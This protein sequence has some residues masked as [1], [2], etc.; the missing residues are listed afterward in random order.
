MSDTDSRETVPEGNQDQRPY[1]GG[2][3][4]MM[5]IFWIIVGV[6]YLLLNAIITFAWMTD[7]EEVSGMTVIYMVVLMVFGLPIM[8]IAFTVAVVKLL[9]EGEL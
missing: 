1:E 2:K 3:R 7:E 4:I 9:V 5:T 8:A 6:A